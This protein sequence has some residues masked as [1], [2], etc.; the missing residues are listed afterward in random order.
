MIDIQ[1]QEW[2]SLLLRWAHLIAGIGW[3]GASF[4]FIALDLGLKRS[5]QDVFGVTGESWSVHG[6]GFYHVRKYGVA[7]QAMPKDLHWYQWDAYATWLTGFALM[8]VVYYLGAERYLIDPTV[9]ELSAGWAVALSVLFLAAGWFVYDGLCRSPL[10]RDGRTLAALLFVLMVATAYGLSLVFSGRAAFLHVG[11]IIATAMSANVFFVIIPNQ[12]KVVAALVAG[13]TPDP[14]LGR[15]AKLRS[16]HNNY[17]TLPVLFMMISNHYPMTF[18]HRWNWVV[19]AFVLLI[20]FVIRHF[21]NRRAAGVRGAGLAWQWPTTVALTLALAAFTGWTP[22]DAGATADG[23]VRTAEAVAIVETH[24]VSCHAAEPTHPWFVDT[25]MEVH[26][27]SETAIR[28][29]ADQILAQAVRTNAMPLGNETGMTDKE[30]AML[31]AW[32]D[33]GMPD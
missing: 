24:C 2:A 32:I 1:V 17:L 18:G 25:P 7:P 23:P 28:A 5:K 6:G 19:V 10:A 4:H 3:I 21:F 30:R 16:T 12:K 27:D 29:R 33:A 15:A 31:G 9:R 8:F 22:P 26:L 20:G 11:A 13:E 14:A